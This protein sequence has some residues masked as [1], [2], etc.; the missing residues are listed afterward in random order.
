MNNNVK[1]PKHYQIISGVE[2]ID[3]IARCMT[4]EQFS[5]FC[6]GNILKYRIRAGKKDALEQDI[7]KA[8]EY[9]NIFENKKRLCVDGG[10]DD[11]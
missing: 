4:V 5:G 2:S 1:N 11:E 3:I 6:L 9:E 7:A 8:N 10:V